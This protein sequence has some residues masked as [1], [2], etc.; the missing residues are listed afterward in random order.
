MG[1]LFLTIFVLLLAQSCAKAVIDNA[2][3]DR[4]S[5]SQENVQ[6]LFKELNN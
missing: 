5:K 4:I 3:S 6:P 1:K 2:G